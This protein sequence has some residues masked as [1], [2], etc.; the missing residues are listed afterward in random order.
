MTNSSD[1]LDRVEQILEAVA[2]RTDTIAQQQQINTRAIELLGQR[3][4]SNAK[5]IQA[6]TESINAVAEAAGRT[7]LAV[8]ILQETVV[9]DR[10]NF[11]E[12]MTATQTTLDSINASIQRQDRIL[13]YLPREHN[14]EQPQP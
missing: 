14:G 2:Q 12:F 8:S 10:V 9:E 4:N 13:D 5:G 6:N 7:L 1:R 11:R 3:V